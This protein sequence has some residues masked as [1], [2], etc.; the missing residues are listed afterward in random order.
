MSLL[1]VIE[2]QD[3]EAGENPLGGI[4]AMASLALAGAA[5]AVGRGYVLAEE[6]L[7]RESAECLNC[8]VAGDALR[9]AH[10]DARKAWDQAR[11]RA[12]YLE[13]WS[14]WAKAVWGIV[15]AAERG[16][17]VVQPGT[18]AHLAAKLAKLERQTKAAAEEVRHG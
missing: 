9:L 8:Q 17:P 12:R 3:E 16:I 14:S 2:K 13:E 15:Q 10:E 4:L 7:E 11:I 18:V 6:E 1:D 5:D